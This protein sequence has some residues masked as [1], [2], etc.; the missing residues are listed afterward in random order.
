MSRK[1]FPHRRCRTEARAR[2]QMSRD[3]R[4]IKRTVYL[5][6]IFASMFLMRGDTA[7]NLK[8]ILKLLVNTMVPEVHANGH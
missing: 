3:L 6:L 2:I 4:K 7:S 1:E 8:W 5:I